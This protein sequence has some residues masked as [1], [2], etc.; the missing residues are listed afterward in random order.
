MRHLETAINLARVT[1][2]PLAA[3]RFLAHVWGDRAV[4]LAC[5][6]AV[7]AVNFLEV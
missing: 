5:L 2:R 7:L 4:V 6:V 3:V 1:G